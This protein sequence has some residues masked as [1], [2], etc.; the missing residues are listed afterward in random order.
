LIKRIP[1]SDLRVGMFIH[2]L[3]CG[4][5]DHP[6]MFNRL[7]ITT[8][9]QLE[10]IVKTGITEVYID[11]RRGFD[12]PGG[13]DAGELSRRLDQELHRVAAARR[14][15]EQSRPLLDELQRARAIYNETQSTIGSMFHEA[16]LGKLPDPARLE[17]L[18]QKIGDSL[19]ANSGAL[20]ML[21][22]MKDSDCYTF[23]HSVAVGMLLMKFADTV[24]YSSDAVAEIGIGGM[25]HDI[26]K[27]LIPDEVLNKPGKLTSEEF[28]LMQRHPGD[29]WE[30]LRR[31]PS[32]SERQ[33]EITHQHHERLDGRGYP[34][35]LGSTQI[36]EEAKLATIADVYDALTSDRCYHHGIPPTQ[37]LRKLLEWQGTHMDGALI[38]QF[39]RCVGIYPV[40]SLVTLE[41][42]RIGIVIE[43]N[44]S[45]LRTPK[46]LVIYDSNKRCHLRP[47]DLDLSEFRA[48]SDPIT[49]FTTAAKWG[50]NE[51]DYL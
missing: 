6:F 22:R 9:A 31:V 46:L 32:V 10:R 12:V 15:A 20:L 1:V 21:A 36:A 17:P 16:R 24:G 13:I 35:Q 43:Q 44:E 23:Q 38:Q 7:K 51:S 41:S 42:G 26:G 49:G 50:L 33:L 39:I 4:W 45:D 27:M 48:N 2:D 14:P 3:N 47:T 5:L 37:A 19:K 34:R 28:E 11:T 18:V 25:L 30:M 29:G 8:S 40:G